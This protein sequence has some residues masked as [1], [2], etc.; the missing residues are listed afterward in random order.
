MEKLSYAPCSPLQKVVMDNDDQVHSVY[1]NR[2][3]TF[4]SQI[5]QL[6]EDQVC[7]SH[8]GSSSA[9]AIVVIAT[10]FFCF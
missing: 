8:F 10:I 6:E 4:G 5:S 1:L 3:L 2:F 9:C 7:M